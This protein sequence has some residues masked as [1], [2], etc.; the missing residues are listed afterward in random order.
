VF[1]NEIQYKSPQIQLNMK[2]IILLFAVLLVSGCNSNEEIPEPSTPPPPVVDCNCDRVVEV[3]TF[4]I[5]GTPQNPQI[6]YYSSYITINDCTEI[7]KTKNFTTTNPSE[8]PQ[9]GQCR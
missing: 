1:D 7:Q 8:S 5:V 3:S 9:L 2:K 6:N 4:N